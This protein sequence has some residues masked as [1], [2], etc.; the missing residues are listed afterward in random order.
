MNARTR[1]RILRSLGAV[2]PVVAL[3]AAGSCKWGVPSYRLHVTL[4]SGITGTPEAGDHS[5]KEVTTITLDYT[6]ADLLNTIEV[7]VND[8]V[9][10]LE[11]DGSLTLYGDNYKIDARLVDLRGTWKIAMAYSDSS[12]PA[13]DPFMV[14]LTGTNL[15]AGEFTD[16]RGYH[17]NWTARYG[18]LILAYWDWEF[19]T[20]TGTTFGM[21]TTSSTSSFTFT[22]GGLSGTWAAVKQNT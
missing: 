12:I 16:S 9:L 15:S 17:G 10:R 14:T 18:V 13:P 2:L 5:Y 8:G 7:I 4:E 20:F 11:H 21:G 3:L 19:Y 22:G 6:P 1:A